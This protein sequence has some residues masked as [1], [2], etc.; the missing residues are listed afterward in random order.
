[1]SILTKNTAALL[2]SA[3]LFWLPPAHALLDNTFGRAYEPVPAAAAD[4]SRVVYYRTDSAGLANGSALLYV[5]RKFH[6]ALLPGGYSIFCLTP[7]VHSLGAYLNDA[8]AYNGKHSEVFQADLQA[9]KTYFLRVSEH[10]IPQPVA[11][12]VA[13]RELA[14]TNEQLHMLSRASVVVACQTAR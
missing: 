6:T 5:D 7:G 13:E 2:G 3:L 4:Q 9:G 8:P 14:S 10:N 12:T 1:M 11:R